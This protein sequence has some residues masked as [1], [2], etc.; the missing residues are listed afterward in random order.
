MTLSAQQTSRPDFLLHVSFCNSNHK[1]L[2]E[3]KCSYFLQPLLFAVTQECP[4]QAAV[5]VVQDGDQEVF[6]KLKGCRELKKGNKNSFIR[7]TVLL[8]IFLH[9]SVLLIAYLASQ[10]PD[11]VNEL[12]K[13]RRAVCICVVLIAMTDT[14]KRNK[15]RRNNNQ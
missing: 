5:Q 15:E 13:N 2:R 6:V 11:T 4:K 7:K 9:T 14:L 1:T 3:T 8:Q 10:L 12:N